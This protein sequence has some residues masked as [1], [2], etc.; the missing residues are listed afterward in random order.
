MLSTNWQ[1][2]SVV[3]LHFDAGV[4][5]GHNIGSDGFFLAG[6]VNFVATADDTLTVVWNGSRWEELSRSVN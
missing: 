2:G 6:A 4:T 3:S 5:V 1:P